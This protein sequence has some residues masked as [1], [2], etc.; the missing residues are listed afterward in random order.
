M[1]SWF[2]TQCWLL[3]GHSPARTTRPIGHRAEWEGRSDTPA[4][5]RGR[6][7]ECCMRRHMRVTA[8]TGC[9]SCYVE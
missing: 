4:G 6:V 1:P 8:A 2:P 7:D 3:T 5:A 9:A